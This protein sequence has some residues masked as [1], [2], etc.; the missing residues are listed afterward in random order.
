M[1]ESFDA[2]MFVCKIQ[3]GVFDGKLHQEL[4]KLSHEQLEQIAELLAM[5]VKRKKKQD[6]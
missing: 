6:S 5:Q 1:G 3:A 4:A 2:A